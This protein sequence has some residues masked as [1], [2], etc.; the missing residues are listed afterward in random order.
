MK[1][2]QLANL[3]NS[4][5][6]IH[7]GLYPFPLVDRTSDKEGDE[8]LAEIIYM[9]ADNSFSRSLVAANF[10]FAIKLGRKLAEIE[11]LDPAEH[12]PEGFFGKWFERIFGDA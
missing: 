12:K 1:R 11:V 5:N 7:Y 2:E 9:N 3:Y 6:P 8:L 4:L 10:E